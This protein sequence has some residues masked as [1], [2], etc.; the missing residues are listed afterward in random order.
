MLRLPP[1]APDAPRAGRRV[2][3]NR[4]AA[5][6]AVA[7]GDDRHVVRHLHLAGVARDGEQ[8]NQRVA[9]GVEPRM[10][11][12]AVAIAGPQLEDDAAAADRR[13][14]VA[15]GAA[16]AVERGPETVIG[17]L[18]LGEVLEPEPELA[19]LDRGDA[20]Q[21]PADRLLGRL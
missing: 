15:R 7:T 8:V 1:E 12:A 11:A 17:R 13:H 2:D 16:R 5:A 14:V 10:T 3:D 21:R 4:G 20:G 9:R 18:D 19:E 6:H